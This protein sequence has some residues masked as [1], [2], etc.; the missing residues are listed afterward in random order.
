MAR[1]ASTSLAYALGGVMA[2]AV[3]AAVPLSVIA[4]R[5]GAFAIVVFVLPFAAVG[6]LVARRPPGNAIRWI[7]I[8]LAL[9]SAIGSLAGFY[10]LRAY[11][12]DHHGMPLSRLA[13]ALA[14][15]AWLSIL[16]LL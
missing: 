14:P 3:A 6:M 13:V 9:G 11:H 5:P 8:A 7:L 15:L 16:V 10:A 12:V 4:H 1:P 2:L